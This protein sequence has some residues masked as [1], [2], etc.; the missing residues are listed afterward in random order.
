M[1]DGQKCELTMS[2]S[3][4][5]HVWPGT[6]PM[7]PRA[8]TSTHPSDPPR[9][10]SVTCKGWRGSRRGRRNQRSGFAA[11]SLLACGAR[12]ILPDDERQVVDTGHTWFG[13][14]VR[15]SEG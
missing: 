7:L 8:W 1:V 12:A 11:L 15:R 13:S 10:L 5:M 4:A 6:R 3:S 14:A 2:T 9:H